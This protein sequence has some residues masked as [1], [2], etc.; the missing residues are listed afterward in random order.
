[1]TTL[2]MLETAKDCPRKAVLFKNL[3]GE[4][5]KYYV[6]KKVID[7]VIDKI[8]FAGT[9]TS[10][11]EVE[12]Y[13]KDAF[14]ET[15]A[16]GFINDFELE[17]HKKILQN[18]IMRLIE[19]C[20][21]NN[22]KIVKRN[23]TKEITLGGQKTKVRANLLIE[24]D[25]HYDLVIIDRRR[26]QYSLEEPKSI[27][28]INRVLRSEFTCKDLSFGK[29]ITPAVYYLQS[30]ADKT[31]VFMTKYDLK[32]G[33]N[34]IRYSFRDEDLKKFEDEYSKVTIDVKSRKPAN[35]C[36]D[37]QYTLTCNGNF[38]ERKLVKEKL[39]QKS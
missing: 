11:V 21:K 12:E 29:E 5:G 34:V 3:S 33:D 8:D 16:N 24:Y 35:E 38:Q 1:M 4:K 37:C 7:I 22:G 15:G 14:T 6:L 13:I 28:Q 9:G 26:P 2:S 36:A 10:A 30:K 25:D 20:V 27:A 31:N 39:F 19:W 23:L 17:S 18:Q 32:K